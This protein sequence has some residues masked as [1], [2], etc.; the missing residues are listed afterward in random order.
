MSRLTATPHLIAARNA[1]AVAFF[2][3]GLCFASWV[4]RIPDARDG[5]GLSNGGLGL[6]LLTI[7]LGSIV[8]LPSTGAAIGR[9]GTV[10]VLR[11]GAV[12]AALG[13]GTT[14]L[15]L[16]ESVVV[17]GAALFVY[18]VG[19]GVWDVAMNVEGAEVERRLGR[20]VM[21]RF[22]AG[23][24]LGTVVGALLG[25]GLVALDVPAAA[26][27]PTVVVVSAVVVWRGAAA[28][29]PVPEVE[30]SPTPAARA[31]LEPRTLLIGVMVL[32]LAMTEGTA[33]DWLAVA[34]VDGYDVSHAAGVAG[35]G[36]FVAAMT[37][38]RLAGT[39]LLDAFGRTAVLWSTMVLAAVGVLLIVLGGHPALV[40]LGIVLWGAGASLGFPV[41]MS[42]AADDPARA[43]ARVSVVSTIGYAAFLAGPPLLGF[44]GDHVGTLDALLVVAVLLVPAAL[45]VPA[46]REPARRAE[47]G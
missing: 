26:H 30:G 6:L 15:A 42:A 17:T 44:V 25:A 19:I 24:S 13:L 47:V 11:A 16:G 46:A 1:V 20:T 41:G 36:L 35:F 32:A 23:F 12:A 43:A 9:W 31:W 2:L 27:L 29:L 45:A 34:L 40:V 7:A 38:S 14:G 4:S 3:N 5:F 37:V 8:A 22:H 33:N 39:H 21:P 18:G 28:F 10:R